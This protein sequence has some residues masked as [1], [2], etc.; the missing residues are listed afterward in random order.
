VND[1]TM[2]RPKVQGTGT[3]RYRCAVC[4]D[5]MDPADAV[6]VADRSYHPEHA[7]KEDDDGR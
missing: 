4:G 2:P 7:P 3:V 6:I 5:L 1:T